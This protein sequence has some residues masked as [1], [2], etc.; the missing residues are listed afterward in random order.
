MHHRVK[1]GPHHIGSAYPPFFIAE[2]SANHHRSLESALEIVDLAARAGAHALK[3][4]TFTADTITLNAAHPEFLI[5]DKNSLWQGKTLYDLYKEAYLPWEWHA[6]IFER[7][8]AHGLIGFSTPFDETAVDFLEG[9]QIPCYKIASLEIVD[10]PLIAKAAATKKPLIIST[11]GATLAE[12]DQA[13][14]VAKRAGCRELILL[15]CTTAYP[16]TPLDVHLR[17]IPHLEQSFQ[18]PVGLSD[19]TL[20]IG[21]P[22]A[23]IALGACVIEK[24]LTASRKNDTLDGAFSLEPAEFKLLTESAYHAWQALGQVSY[25]PLDS[26]AVSLSH[27][28]SLYFVASLTKDTLIKPEHI[29]SVRPANG[30]APKEFHAIVGLR[31]NADVD[32][33]D[34]VTWDVFK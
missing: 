31:L 11:G 25:G 8:Q 15:K 20:G 14:Q 6:A 4:Q 23:S 13:V 3:V 2:M 24:H 9:L 33:G 34:P 10:H 7:C 29:R 30:L 32:L 28:P 27:R 12:I 26:E 19:H 16:T 22:I 17:T 5:T 18:V 21:V 1:I